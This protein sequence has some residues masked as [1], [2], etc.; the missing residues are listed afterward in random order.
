MDHLTWRS[1]SI[2]YRQTYTHSSAHLT[3]QRSAMQCCACSFVHTKKNM[4]VH[5]IRACGVGVVFL[6]PGVHGI[7]LQVACL[8]PNIR[9]I[10]LLRF[11][12]PCE[13]AKPPP[14]RSA[15]YVSTFFNQSVWCLVRTAVCRGQP[16][17]LFAR[18]V[19]STSPIST[20]TLYVSVLYSKDWRIGTDTGCAGCRGVGRTV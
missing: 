8:D 7:Y 12:L 2:E 15:S 1:T 4:Y 20:H 13:R 16:I 10:Y 19:Q 5:I 3:R 9:T 11:I 6:E 17:S 18:A 14:T